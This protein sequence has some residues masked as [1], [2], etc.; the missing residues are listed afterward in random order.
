M[1]KETQKFNQIWIWILLGLSGLIPIFAFGFGI[2]KQIILGQQFGNNPMSNNGLI[3]SFFLVLLL[4]GVLTYLFVVANLTTVIDSTGVS[5]KFFPFHLKYHKLSWNE[6][7]SY[8]VV[9]YH[10]IR[11]Y[12]GWGIRFVKGGKAFNTSGDKGLQLYLKTGKKLL[13]G[14]QNEQELT[15]FLSEI[16]K[17][18]F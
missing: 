11:D 9:T 2:Y 3:T 17:D 7:A 18:N 1:Y 16:K 13:I 4:F 5:Y 15:R 14:T 8:D 6:I 12:G 10:P